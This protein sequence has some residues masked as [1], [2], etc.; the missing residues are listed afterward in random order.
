MKV[1][2]HD[3]ARPGTSVPDEVAR[4]VKE[5]HLPYPVTVVENE[6]VSA[7]EVSYFTIADR[8]KQAIA[9]IRHAGDAAD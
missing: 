9:P 3:L 7:G 6:I 8:V 1:T 5:A 2:Y 4:R